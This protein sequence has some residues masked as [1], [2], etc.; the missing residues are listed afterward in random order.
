M[1][2]GWTGISE[3]QD[4]G[5]EVE[6]KLTSAFSNIDSDI[7]KN[8]SNISGHDDELLAITVDISKIE[9]GTQ[10]IA[11]TQ[12]GDKTGSEP[13]WAKGQ[14]FYADGKLNVDTAHDGVRLQVGEE[15]HVTV[16]N[17]TGATLLNGSVVKY[18][19]VAAGYPSVALSQAD[20]FDNAKDI[21]VLTIDIPDGQTGILTMFGIV[22]G[23]NLSAFNDGDTL[24][25]SASV[26]GAYVASPPDIASQVG[27]VFNNDGT[28]GEMF[29]TPRQHLNLPT[30][31]AYLGNGILNTGTITAAYQD[32]VNYMSSGNVVMDYDAANGTILIPSTGIYT[33]TINM[34][35]IFDSV[36]N[37][38]ETFN[39][40]ILGSISGAQDLP[41]I[42]GRTG[43]YASAY[44]KVSFAAT[45]GETLKLQLGGASTDITGLNEGMLGFEVESK[46]IR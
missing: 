6:A 24:Y 22:R 34:V 8:A 4:T 35:T 30:V 9:E 21:G 17:N 43:A 12:Y 29:V 1:S 16:Y 40:R 10:E 5:N 2:S 14:V 42:I 11:K 7:A 27:T 41:V 26:A 18:D 45:A 37:S 13:V 39:L 15:Q 3:G 23:L 33:I 36:G 25:V 38:A 32:V 28:N 31:L 20:T 19:G 46:H 44:P